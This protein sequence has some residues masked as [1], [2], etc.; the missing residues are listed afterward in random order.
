MTRHDHWK[1][2]P[3]ANEFPPDE[4]DGLERGTMQVCEEFR[5]PRPVNGSRGNCR[6]C[7]VDRARDGLDDF[8]DLP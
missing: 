5:W 8:P 3:H 4:I 6:T 2:S 7:R 1:T